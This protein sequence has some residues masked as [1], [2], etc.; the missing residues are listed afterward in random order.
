[1]VVVA[2][3]PRGLPSVL[4]TYSSLPLFH[5]GTVHQGKMSVSSKFWHTRCLLHDCSFHKQDAECSVISVLDEAYCWLDNI[6]S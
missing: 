2:N 5:L 4:C 6:L 3:R 1:M